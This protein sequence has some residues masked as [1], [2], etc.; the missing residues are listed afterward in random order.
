MCWWRLE[1]L[2]NSGDQI[3][4]AASVTN[5]RELANYNDR[6]NAIM[7]TR[8]V[9]NNHFYDE[10]GTPEGK[11][12]INGVGQKPKDTSV[13]LMLR[14]TLCILTKEHRRTD[15]RNTSRRTLK[16]FHL[17]GRQ[18]KRYC[19]WALKKVKIGLNTQD[20]QKQLRRSIQIIVNSIFFPYHE[21]LW[22]H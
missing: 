6:K 14:M 19:S 16:Q 2:D 1:A 20:S 13:V 9:P 15:G 10:L 7:V 4:C 21:D 17:P 22:M 18:I 11:I 12:S 5:K 8:P 3:L